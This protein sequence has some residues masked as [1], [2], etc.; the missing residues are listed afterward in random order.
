MPLSGLSVMCSLL[1]LS[2]LYL[3]RSIAMMFRCFFVMLSCI[4]MMFLWHNRII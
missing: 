2:L 3:V 4:F 1:M